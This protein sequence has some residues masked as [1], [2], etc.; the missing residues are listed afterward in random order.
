MKIE[1]KQNAKRPH[2]AAAL[3]AIASAAVLTGCQAGGVT[4]K[5]DAPVPIY[6]GD[7][8]T[9]EQIAPAPRQNGGQI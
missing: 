4:I 6:E 7:A 8:D 5:G 3:A 9:A 2:Y 1:P